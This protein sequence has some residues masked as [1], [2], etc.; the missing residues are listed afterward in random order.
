MRDEAQANLFYKRSLKRLLDSM[1]DHYNLICLFNL[2]CGCPTTT[3]ATNYA[4]WA[5][6]KQLI[7]WSWQFTPTHSSPTAYPTRSYEGLEPIE[8][9][10]T[11]WEKVPVHRRA[12]GN[13]VVAFLHQ[14][15]LPFIWRIFNK[16]DYCCWPTL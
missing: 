8:R 11:R 12:V 10:G 7:S 4:E 1:T 15:V 13:S 5:K 9:Q 14:W 3:A 2:T 6:W 16:V